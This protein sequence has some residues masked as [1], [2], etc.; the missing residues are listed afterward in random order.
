[1]KCADNGSIIFLY[2]MERT[3]TFAAG[4]VCVSLIQ[5]EPFHG[6]VESE[7]EQSQSEVDNEHRGY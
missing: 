2:V 5:G 7:G 1:M 4:M 3:A 6:A